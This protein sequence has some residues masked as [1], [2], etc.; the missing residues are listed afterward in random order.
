M[1]ILTVALLMML[2][3]CSGEDVAPLK[4][5]SYKLVDS[6]NNIPTIVSFAENGRFNGKVVNN[7]MGSYKLGDNGR[8]SFSPI[9][10]TLMM[11]PEDAMEAEQNFL[12]ILPRIKSYK[13]QGNYL[14]L[15]TDNGG[16]LVFEPHTPEDT[17]VAE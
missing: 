5:G 15:I 10:T 12:Q 7:M 11:G 1:R 14:V 3:A 8:I 17:A 6:L 9:A 13:M 2:A 16:E 4:T